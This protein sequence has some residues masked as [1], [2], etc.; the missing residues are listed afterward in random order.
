MAKEFCSNCGAEI[1]PNANF[2]IICG[3]S[4]EHLP[5]E[6]KTEPAEKNI[7][8]PKVEPEAEP[9]TEP[10]EEIKAEPLEE[11][12][13]KPKLFCSE[14]GAELVSDSNF[15]LECG[16]PVQSASA[17]EVKGR[18]PECGAEISVDEKF[19]LNCGFQLNALRSAAVPIS[20]EAAI[21]SPTAA[22]KKSPA[23]YII[24]IASAVLVAL[25]AVFVILIVVP[26]NVQDM[27]YDFSGFQGVYNGSARSSVPEGNGTWIY[28]SSDVK[29]SAEG[30]WKNGDLYNGTAILA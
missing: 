22:A 9:K 4:I 7:T 15:C 30:E 3:T 5:E 24:I 20:A 1:A 21:V 11:S 26:R 16:A 18:C 12:K 28:N 6:T 14:C 13:E 23:K 8:E 25:A 19:C 29:I 10:A 17:S 2:C 27:K